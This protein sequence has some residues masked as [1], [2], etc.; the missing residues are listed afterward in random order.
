MVP[1]AEDMLLRGFTTVRDTCGNTHGLRDAINAGAVAGPRIVS[2]GACIGGGSSHAD[3]FT[4]TSVKGETNAE[5]VGFSRIAD[6]PDEIRLAIRE[7][8]RKGAS[9]IKLMIGGGLASTYDPIDTNTMSAEEI[10]AAVEET[11]SWGTYATAHVYND[12]GINRALDAGMITLEHM[13]LGSRK[14]YQR[15]KKMGLTLSAQ[16]AV[17]QGLK[18]NPVFVTAEAQRK[19]AFMQDNGAAVFE[20]MRE[21]K[22]PVGFGVDS[23]GSFEAFRFNSKAIRLRKNLFP[24]EMILEQIFKN[25]V[26]LLEMTGERLPY[27]DGRLGRIEEG[28]YAD[29]L[30]V[31]GDPTEDVAI[32]ADWDKNIDLIMK[33]GVIYKNSL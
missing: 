21:L 26:T 6:G 31:K 32:F 18:G 4:D 20:Y 12:V 1:I 11:E 24:N 8:M 16:V 23:Y 30:L 22:I 33:D 17:V 25:N 29:L 15:L 27:K 13:H 2:A 28:A 19:A 14:T 9:F 3:F 7:E 10:R 5:R